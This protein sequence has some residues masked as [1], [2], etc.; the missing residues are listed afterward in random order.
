MQ[1]EILKVFRDLVETSSFS[2]A[3]NLNSITQSAV[4]QQI[5]A[6]ERKFKV[7]LVERGKNIF[8]VTV[9][10][11]AFLQAS[12]EILRAYEGLSDR[13]QELQA[14]IAGKLNIATVYSVGLHEFPRHLKLFRSSYPAVEVTVE[15]LRSA[16][17]YQRVADGAAHI[18]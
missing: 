6:L 18:G 5:H 7:S 12:L 3:A 8:S 11:R 9:E 13:L 16:Q 4:S 2:K 1:I 17:V 10:G 14:T 15:Y